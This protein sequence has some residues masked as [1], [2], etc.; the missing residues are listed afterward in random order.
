MI[1]TKNENNRAGVFIPCGILRNHISSQTPALSHTVYIYRNIENPDM[2]YIG[3]TSMGLK[4]RDGL[5]LKSKTSIP[6]DGFYRKHPSKYSLSILKSC[7]SDQEAIAWEKIMIA[8][9]NSIWPNGYNFM[10]G[11]SGGPGVWANMSE[12][13]KKQFAIGKS[14]WAK[15]FMNRPGIK[16]ILSE[17][18]KRYANLPEVK[19]ARSDRMIGD[20]NPNRD[21]IYGGIKFRK[22]KTLSEITKQKIRESKL[23]SKN[24]NYANH[25][26]WTQTRWDAQEKWRADKFQ[27]LL[28]ERNNIEKI[29][30]V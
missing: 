17:S 2:V 16:K 6:F 26:P 1:L 5:H 3:K 23:G 30:E 11:G 18:S 19:I 22:D 12:E 29:K 13:K 15:E 8:Q 20:K 4:K 14:K 24:P 7:N 10:P 25:K 28:D 27:Q 9:F 21:G